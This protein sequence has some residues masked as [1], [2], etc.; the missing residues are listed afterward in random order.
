MGALGRHISTPAEKCP[1]CGKCNVKDA[2]K[3]VNHVER[4]NETADKLG[5]SK[6]E[7]N[8]AVHVKAYAEF[9]KGRPISDVELKN[10]TDVELPAEDKDLA[11][12]K[13]YIL[14]NGFVPSAVAMHIVMLCS[15]PLVTPSTTTW[16]FTDRANVPDMVFAILKTPGYLEGI[17]PSLKIIMGTNVG[18]P[19]WCASIATT[20]AFFDCIR[21]L[22]TLKGLKNE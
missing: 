10:L 12:L 3:A 9:I 2:R 6:I 11:A 22:P 15:Q 5:I 20:I 19:A 13:V 7:D 16:D 17:W 1:D 14:S 21:T 8:H 4:Y 18:N